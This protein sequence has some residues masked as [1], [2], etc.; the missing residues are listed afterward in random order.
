MFCVFNKLIKMDDDID[1]L[2]SEV[3]SKFCSKSKA[4]ASHK[5]TNRSANDR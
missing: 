5:A 4:S 1:D 3:E 2:L